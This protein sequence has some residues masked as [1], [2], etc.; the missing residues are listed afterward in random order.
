[1]LYAGRA[2]AAAPATG[3]GKI[4]EREQQALV[5]AALHSTAT[6][7]SARETTRLTA[8]ATG[9]SPA[10]S[11]AATGTGAGAVPPVTPMRKRS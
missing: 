8:L 11:P 3:I 4:H 5:S 9:S 1:V 2:P 7:E 6:E 10:S